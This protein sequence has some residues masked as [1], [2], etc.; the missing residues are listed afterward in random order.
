MD[1]LIKILK[2]IFLTIAILIGLTILGVAFFVYK[3]M[4]SGDLTNYVAKTAIENTDIGDKLTE[5]QKEMLEAG[6]YEALAEDVGE[7]LTPEQIDCA[8]QVLGPQRAAELEKSMDP[9]PQEVLK[10]SKCL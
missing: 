10:L 1:K 8:V 6:D 9:T 2:I 3:G 7:N 5:E 4:K